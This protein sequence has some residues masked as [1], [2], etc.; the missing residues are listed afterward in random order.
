MKKKEL[1]AEFTGTTLLLAA[2]AG[3]AAAAQGLTGNGAIRGII[4]GLSTSIALGLLIFLFSQISGAHFNP[5]VS[6]VEFARKRISTSQLF[7]YLVAQFS[8]A[9]F[10]VALANLMYESP[11]FKLSTIERSGSGI[12]LGEVIATFGLLFVINILRI[13][14]KGEFAPVAV[15]AWIISAYLFTS[16]TALANPAVTVARMWADNISGVA[17]R[18]LWD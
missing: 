1:L 17:P 11:I 8:G 13:Q 3:S 9:V 5:A 18:A 7:G 4:N 12:Y 10:G 15:A 16:S 2:N 14:K 6:I